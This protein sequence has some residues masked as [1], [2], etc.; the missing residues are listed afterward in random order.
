[1]AEAATGA[2]GWAAGWA[3]EGWAARADLVADLE[4]EEAEE[5][6]GKAASR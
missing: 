6:K 3:A 1:M 5:S 4:A 2:V